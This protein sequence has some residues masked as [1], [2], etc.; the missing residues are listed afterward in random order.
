MSSSARADLV[1]P[2]GRVGRHVREHG[3]N[4]RV[5]ASV[6]PYMAAVLEYLTAEL[7]LV[8]GDAA[9]DGKRKRIQPAHIRTAVSEDSELEQLIGRTAV[10]RVGQ[11]APKRPA[12]APKPAKKKKLS[13]SVSLPAM[14]VTTPEAESDADDDSR[15]ESVPEVVEPRKAAVP[16]KRM[17]SV[18]KPNR[19]K[20][21]APP[22]P[23]PK[24]AVRP[25]AP[26]KKRKKMP[27]VKR[28][29]KATVAAPAQALA[30]KA[31]A[32]ARKRTPGVKKAG[33]KWPKR[34]KKAAA[35]PPPTPAPSPVKPAKKVMPFEPF[36]MPQPKKALAS[37][38]KALTHPNAPIGLS[39][40]PTPDILVRGA[41]KSDRE[42]MDAFNYL[43]GHD[44]M[45]DDTDAKVPAYRQTAQAM[46]AQR[47]RD[48]PER[49]AA[50]LKRM[51]DAA[52]H[53][54]TVHFAQS[55][56]PIQEA[57]LKFILNSLLD[58]MLD[59]DGLRIKVRQ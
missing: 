17:P 2:V 16:R 37:L 8:A 19:P 21:T 56:R 44:W 34:P 36:R 58:S 46:F 35:A 12:A 28:T 24:A 3:A 55:G 48:N 6:A 33:I 20:K 53:R 14:R 26:V 4:M 25:S 7:L 47:W 11:P 29:K 52:M 32:P 5:G 23:A 59:D 40:H 38:P 27:G 42:V 31:A 54:N 43:Y 57:D 30:P 10:P 22:V 50:A 39:K 13:R 49:H 9:R 15:S 41:Q 45:V 1:F 51:R 18:K